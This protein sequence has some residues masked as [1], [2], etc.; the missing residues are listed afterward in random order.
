MGHTPKWVR[1]HDI[2]YNAT[3][4]IRKRKRSRERKSVKHLNTRKLFFY[5]LNQLLDKRSMVGS[6]CACIVVKFSDLKKKRTN[7]K[8]ANTYKNV[9]R[10]D[11]SLKA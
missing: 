7:Y 1:L 4:W 9:V 3:K 10:L 6:I 2:N 5:C 11:L 8:V